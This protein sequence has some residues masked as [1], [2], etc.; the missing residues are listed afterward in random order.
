MHY[1]QGQQYLIA[2]EI[3]KAETELDHVSRSFAETGNMLR[4]AE[5]Y[6][7]AE[8]GTEND[9]K[10]A[11]DGLKDLLPQCDETLQPIVQKKYDSV[12]RSYHDLL[13][14]AACDALEKR[15]FTTAQACLC[16]IPEYPYATELLC[17]AQAGIDAYSANTSAELNAVQKKLN[18]IPVDYDGPCAEQL[19]ILRAN[20]ADMITAAEDKEAAV[21]KEEEDRVKALEAIGLP[22]EG[23]AESKV[24]STRQLGEAAYSWTDYIDTTNSHGESVRKRWNVY[25]WYA[26]KDSSLVFTAICENSR[27]IFADKLGG[28]AYWNGDELLVALSPKI[29]PKSNSKSNS[30][31]GGTSSSSSH[32]IR[33]EYDPED[34][35]EDNKDWYADEDEAWDEWYDG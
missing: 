25:A 33:D 24:N 30:N 27:V 21:K 34:L 14:A 32:S 2:G 3:S 35:W 28:E 15:N 4:Y 31:S 19:S 5:L 20:L 8:S 11:L 26:K 13:Y 22:Y 9:L 18:T 16:Q 1:S 7:L 17:F 29:I 10:N 6:H 23:M 12:C